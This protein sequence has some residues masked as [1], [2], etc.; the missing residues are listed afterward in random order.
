MLKGKYD[1]E[2]INQG[3]TPQKN[4]S[5]T[6]INVRRHQNPDGKRK[7]SLDGIIWENEA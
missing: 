1:I 3:E 4:Y 2:A 6:I 7:A 5:A